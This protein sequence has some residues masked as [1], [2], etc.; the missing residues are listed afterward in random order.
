MAHITGGGIE[1]NTRRV[2][3]EGLQIRVNYQSWKRL[4][5]FNLIKERGS[6]PEDD[7]R[8]TFN[9]GIGL[10]V[11]T[12]PSAEEDVVRIAATHKETPIAIGT[13]Y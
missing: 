3:P 12:S 5:V 9:L 8:S 2:L 4:P 11:I 13:V 1:G 10:V 7:M 6:V